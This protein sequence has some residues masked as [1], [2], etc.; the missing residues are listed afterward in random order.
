MTGPYSPAIKH[1]FYTDTQVFDQWLTLERNNTG[2][3][4]EIPKC[5]SKINFAKNGNPCDCTKG[6]WNGIGK[7]NPEHK[8]ATWCMR[9]KPTKGNHAQQCCYDAQGNLMTGLPAAGTPDYISNDSN[10]R[11][12]FN[13]DLRPWWK[14]EKLKREDD[15]GSVRPPSNGGGVCY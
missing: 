5:P 9:S 13:H 12:H 8:N 2:W 6:S 15:Y 10:M 1:E 11:G 7:A 4:N 3:L 14:A